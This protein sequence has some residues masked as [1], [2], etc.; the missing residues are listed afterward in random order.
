MTTT[1]S[2]FSCDPAS[3]SSGT[4]VTETSGGLSRRP[5]CSRH[6]RYSRETRGCSSAS[7]Q[8]SCSRS[9]KTRSATRPR[10]I[11]PPSFRTPSPSRST[12][13]RLTPSSLRSRWWTI[14]SLETVAA[15]SRANARSA[16]VFP[17]PIPPVIATA[18]GRLKL[19]GLVGFF[20]GGR[21]FGCG[22]GFGLDHWL[23]LGRRSRLRLGL[24]L[25]LGNGLDR[26]HGDRFVEHLNLLCGRHFAR[27]RVAEHVLGEIEVRGERC[28]VGARL[29]GLA[30][31]DA[32]ERER[33]APPVGVDLD[34][35]H[36]H[37]VALGDDL[38][39]ILDVVLRQ[40]GDVHEALDAREDLHEGAERDHLRHAALD[41]VALA[42]GLDDLLPRVGLRLLETERDPLALAVDV[43]HLDLHVLSDLEHLGRMVD[44]APREL[45]DV[46]EAVHPVEVDEGAEVDDVRDLAVDDVAGVEPVEDRLAHLLALVLEHGAPRE[47]D[48]V[49]RAVELDHLGAKLL[50][51]ELVEVV[52]PPDVDQRGR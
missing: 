37:D 10:S 28:A 11:S 46:D 18:T 24:R 47:D 8:A 39:R 23:G 41:H 14:S 30:L 45:G 20:V 17:A 25:D 35:L 15:P 3:K 52:H 42:V 48:V 38:A 6:V 33:E 22:C 2:K 4:S 19:C 26:A 29:D 40:L 9:S 7:S 49:A 31:L 1:A 43:E 12:I 34:H 27:G 50:A 21:G 5:S 13:A 36:V 51:E 44:V 16:S 32:L